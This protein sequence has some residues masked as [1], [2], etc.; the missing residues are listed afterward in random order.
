MTLPYNLS[1]VHVNMPITNLIDF[2]EKQRISMEQLKIRSTR[3]PI[4]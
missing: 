3:W 2:K 1:T 4:S